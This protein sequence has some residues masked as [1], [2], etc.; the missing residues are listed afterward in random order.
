M[1][2]KEI[3]SRI[4]SINVAP[5]EVRNYI[6][7]SQIGSECY[8]KI[9]YEYNKYPGTPITHKILRTFELSGLT[10]TTLFSPV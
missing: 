5:D 9:W 1:K 7:A 4:D 6:G 3:S 8:R 10:P 2:T